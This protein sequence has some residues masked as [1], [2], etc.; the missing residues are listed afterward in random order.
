MGKKQDFNRDE[1]GERGD[2][3]ERTDEID[4][5]EGNKAGKH[6]AERSSF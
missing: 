6:W 4:V 1:R 5:S 3:R 2:Y